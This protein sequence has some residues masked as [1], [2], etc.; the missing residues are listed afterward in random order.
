MASRPSQGSSTSHVP[1]PGSQYVPLEG[2]KLLRAADPTEHITVTVVVRPRRPA[3]A[4]HDDQSLAARLPRD[5]SYLSREDFE[6]RHGAHPDDLARIQRFAREHSFEIVETSAIRHAVVLQGSIAD[7]SHAFRVEIVHYDHQRGSHRGINGPV[8]IPKELAGTVTAVLGLHDRPCAR[9]HTPA[10]AP[11]RAPSPSSPLHPSEVAGA[12]R[13][14]QHADG[15]GQCIGIIE[16]GGGYYR[17]D[18]EKFFESLKLPVPRISDVA[19]HGAKNSPADR[20]A[21]AKFMTALTAGKKG[22]AAIKQL[23]TAN[24]AKSRRESD[25]LQSTLETTMDIEIAAAFAPGAR[26]VVYFADNSEQGIY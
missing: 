23:M 6:S 7:F 8:Y 3:P 25:L 1:I 5:R 15:T 18:L 22:T 12:Y 11:K 9:R 13:F 24:D 10:A 14:P 16:L 20:A 17:A 2:A 19:V 21:L 4:L 26:L